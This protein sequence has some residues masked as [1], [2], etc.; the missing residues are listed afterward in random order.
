MLSRVTVAMS[1]YNI[2]S[3][4]MELKDCTLFACTI[5]AA[6]SARPADLQC[7]LHKLVY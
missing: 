4:C 2:T 1:I 6:A 7:L 3:L 5:E